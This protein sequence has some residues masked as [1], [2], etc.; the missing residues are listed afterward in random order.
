MIVERVVP[1][2]T[3]GTA[4]SRPPRQLPQADATRMARARRGTKSGK[5]IGRPR[6]PA[7]LIRSRNL[8]PKRRAIAEMGVLEHNFL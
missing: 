6:I 7:R 2:Q 8:G 4:L 3:G 1:R 5:A